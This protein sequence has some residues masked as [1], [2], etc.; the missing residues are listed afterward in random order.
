MAAI[1][2]SSP[3]PECYTVDMLSE[4]TPTIGN[5]GDTVHSHL[6]SLTSICY[7]PNH[8][9]ADIQNQVNTTD[10]IAYVGPAT[11]RI[12]S[13]RGNLPATRKCISNFKTVLDECIG[14]VNF[15]G[16]IIHDDDIEYSIYLQS[17]YTKPGGEHNLEARA[18][19]GS[20]TR[21]KTRPRH[22]PKSKAKQKKKSKTVSKSK[23]K[24]KSK[25]KKTS[26]I[27]SKP[28]SRSK[29][30]S[31]L[32]STPT[33][34]PTATQ[35]KIKIGPTKNCKQ[36]AMLMQKPSKGSKVVRDIE[37]S[38]G[39]FVGSRLNIDLRRDLSKR[40]DANDEDDAWNFPT[41]ADTRRNHAGGTPKR[42]SACGAFFNALNYPDKRSMV[43]IIFTEK[44]FC[45]AALFE[46]GRAHV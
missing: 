18:R 21:T 11:I 32:K 19:G 3:L 13:M 4:S 8:F 34:K 14:Q 45:T 46:I 15:A 42:G 26:T 5:F 22:K 12:S 2:V 44:L 38:R 31:P 29:S 39:S 7:Q 1:V 24:S 43:R 41:A 30:K 33:Q 20:K 35:T 27:K 25:K 28:K 16:G 17:E 10:F 37:E 40:V 36:I 23:S 9:H 6:T